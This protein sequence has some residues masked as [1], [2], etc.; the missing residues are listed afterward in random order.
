[1]RRFVLGIA[2]AAIALLYGFHALASNMTIRG[3]LIDLACYSEDKSNTGNAHKGYGLICAR[4]CAL[5]GFPVGLLT[6]NGKVYRIEGRLAANSNAKL[7]PHMAETVTI[8]GE[9]AEEDGQS[10][11]TADSLN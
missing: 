10:T 2:A 11:I 9:T 5:E 8:S 7:V 1:M 4:A 6:A 3:Q